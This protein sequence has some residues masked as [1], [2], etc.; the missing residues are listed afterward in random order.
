MEGD[1]WLYYCSLANARQ[2]GVKYYNG[3]YECTVST[4]VAWYTVI[5]YKYIAQIKDEVN[6]LDTIYSLYMP[7][8]NKCGWSHSPA[9]TE[10]INEFC[11]VNT[12]YLMITSAEWKNISVESPQGDLT[13]FP[14]LHPPLHDT[15]AATTLSL[16]RSFIA[17]CF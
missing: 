11:I 10:N 14:S 3:A 15:A 4:C 9:Y 16:C 5:Y 12:A 1:D 13:Q 7:K 6:H 8:R 2:N 17:I